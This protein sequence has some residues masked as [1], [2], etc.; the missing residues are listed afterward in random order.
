MFLI[1]YENGIIE[2]NESY[3]EEDIESCD[4]GI[5]QLIDI[6]NPKSPL[7]YYDKEWEAIKTQIE[8]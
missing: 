4:N 1:I 2:K 3:T 6:T 5:M 8:E 7:E